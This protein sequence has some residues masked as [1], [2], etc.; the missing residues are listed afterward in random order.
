MDQTTSGKQQQRR[1]RRNA[2]DNARLCDCCFSKKNAALLTALAHAN[3]SQRIALLRSADSS[4][5]RCICECVLNILRGTIPIHVLAKKKLR[6]HAT[7]L[8]RLINEKGDFK[9]KRKSL[10]QSGGSFLPTLLA[11]LLVEFAS[12]LARG[13]TSRATPRSEK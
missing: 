10:I 1:R 9:V 12:T 7:T 6:K 8:R 11:P 13:F 4:F 3:T 2:S 5:I